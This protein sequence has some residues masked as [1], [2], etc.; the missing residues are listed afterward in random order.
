[1]TVHEKKARELFCEGYNCS[2]SLFAAF[3]DVTG[4][5]IETALKISSSFGGGIG[6][7]REVCGAFS[8]MCMAVG[9]ICGYTNACDSNAKKAEYKIVQELAEDFKNRNGSYMCYE[10]LG[11]PHSPQ[12]PVP[13]KRDGTFFERRPCLEIVADA[14]KLLDEY[15]DNK[16]IIVCK[17][18]E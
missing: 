5:D 14:A 10:L 9:M 2:Q 3:C 6:R 17:E 7:L 4:L 1:M 8:G 16:R 13:Q 11:V 18:V 15:I 12:E